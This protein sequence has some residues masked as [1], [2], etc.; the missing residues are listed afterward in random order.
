[1]SAAAHR[2]V[3]RHYCVHWL[4]ACALT[5][6]GCAAASQTTSPKNAPTI[7]GYCTERF[8]R[9]L[10]EQYIT[11]ERRESGYLTSSGHKVFVRG[12]LRTVATEGALKDGRGAEHA[13][14]IGS[15]RIATV[16]LFSGRYYHCGY[17]G[18]GL[19][20]GCEAVDGKWA[21]GYGVL[22]QTEPRQANLG[23]NGQAL[24]DAELCIQPSD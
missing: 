22:R 23:W 8:M 24:D 3:V 18:W 12:Q 9:N 17:S 11:L 10:G 14:A 16:E 4:L 6:A 1:M 5:S 20:P 7:L 2:S 13:L 15:A 21:I 19:S